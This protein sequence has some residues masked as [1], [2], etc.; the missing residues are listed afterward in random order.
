MPSSPPPVNHGTFVRIPLSRPMARGKPAKATRILHSRGV[1]RAKYER[2]SAM[3]AR[4]GRVRSDAWR[5]CRGVSTVL[6]SPYDVRDARMAEGCARHGL[7][8]R[9]GKAVPRGRRP[10]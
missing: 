9:L 5:R 3:A 7:P 6:Q 2:L 10:R 4:C 1:N 8:A